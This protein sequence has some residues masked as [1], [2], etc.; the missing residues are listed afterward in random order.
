P[1][2]DR[3]D[4][5]GLGRAREAR[6][7]ADP[8]DEDDPLAR[9]PELWEEALD[10][11]QD[12]VVPAARAPAALLV[13]LELLR[14]QAAVSGSVAHSRASIASAS[15]PARSGTPRTRLSPT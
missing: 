12:R 6:R 10:C 8:R 14:R 11:G 9:D 1:P 3:V 13:C 7:A 2:G 15:S 5:V 4:P